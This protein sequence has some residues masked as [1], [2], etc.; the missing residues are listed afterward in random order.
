MNNTATEHDFKTYIENKLD[1]SSDHSLF[2]FKT[3]EEFGHFLDEHDI[4][5]QSELGYLFTFASI[6]GG[7]R[8][9]VGRRLVTHEDEKCLSLTSISEVI[10][11]DL[12]LVSEAGRGYAPERGLT[13][14][15]SHREINGAWPE[16]PLNDL[17]SLQIDSQAVDSL[18]EFFDELQSRKQTL[19]EIFQRDF[20]TSQEVHE[21]IART[22]VFDLALEAMK[23][24]DTFG[25][26]AAYDFLEFIV[27][28]H[29]HKWLVPARIKPLYVEGNGPAESLKMIYNPEGESNKIVYEQPIRQGLRRLESFGREELNMNDTEIVFDIESCLCTHHGEINDG[30]NYWR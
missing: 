21:G 3:Q 24:M 20:E 27:R 23:S 17:E 1:S 10:E 12:G 22:A 29:G 5:R 9:E 15:H 8:T 4:G 26:L 19:E 30:K 28:V 13:E 7:W 18:T 16:R 11:A 2:E 14:G 6:A 25:R